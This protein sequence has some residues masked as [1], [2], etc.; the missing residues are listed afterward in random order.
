M[1]FIETELAGSF[2]ITVEPYSDQRGHFGRTFCKQEFKDLGLESE[3]VQSNTS[4][5]KLSGTLRGMHYQCAPYEEAKLVSCTKGS[6]YDVIIDTRPSSV[7]YGQFFSI[8]LSEK[9][10][11]ML[12]IPKG[13]AHGFQTLE[14]NS[15]ASY[16]MFE[17]YNPESARGLRWNDPFFKIKWPIEN[18]IISDKDQNYELFNTSI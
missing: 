18:A 15:I 3:I 7:T 9:N 10:N 14:D 13:F 17:F 12:Y 1:K 11:T 16:Q 8:E 5:N 2:V 6:I 4:Y